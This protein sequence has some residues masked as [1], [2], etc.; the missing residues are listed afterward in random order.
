MRQFSD[1]PPAG[2]STRKEEKDEEDEEEEEEQQGEEEEEEEEKDHLP[3]RTLHQ[4]AM[5]PL[6][7]KE[8]KMV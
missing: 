6:L 5:V 7:D 4:E 8:R 1:H 3:S 2:H